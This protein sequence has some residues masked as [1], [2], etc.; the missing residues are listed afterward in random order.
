MAWEVI[1]TRAGPSHLD[2]PVEPAP[3]FRGAVLEE[4]TTW[5]L[6][7]CVVVD[8]KRLYVQAG[9]PSQFREWRDAQGR[10]A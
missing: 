4:S 1:S 2:A 10:P 9:S 8:D 6:C 3:L 7:L 5:P